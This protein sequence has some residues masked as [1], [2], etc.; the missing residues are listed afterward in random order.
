MVLY[1]GGS[2]SVEY[3]WESTI[4]ASTFMWVSYNVTVPATATPGWYN[5]TVCPDNAT[6][7]G[8]P[9][10]VD[11]FVG[12]EEYTQC[13][14]CNY[15][16]YVA[17]PVYVTGTV[18]EIV[19]NWMRAGY[20]GV[21]GNLTLT[22]VNV[23]AL[24]TTTNSSITNATGYYNISVA[25]GDY[26]LYAS[27]AGFATETY[28]AVNITGLE[29]GPVVVNFIGVNGLE[30]SPAPFYTPKYALSYALRAGN[31]W[32]VEP[33]SSE[34]VLTGTESLNITNLWLATP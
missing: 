22:G 3:D 2:T 23:T 33:P 32:L 19:W 16:I 15:S 12:E 25:P 13:I 4:P 24:D 11:Y 28:G 8:W 27:L 31:L 14:G 9:V 21:P 30:P 17:A 7:E 20:M 34:A 5:M 26:I 6:P 29:V 1:G 18:R 10:W